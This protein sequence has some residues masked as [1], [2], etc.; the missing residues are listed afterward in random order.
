MWKMPGVGWYQEIQ[1][2][3]S[4]HHKPRAE[5]AYYHDTAEEIF[6]QNPIAIPNLDLRNKNKREILKS[7]Q[8]KSEQSRVT[9]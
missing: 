1:W 8:L 5:K 7:S 9:C 6:S 4:F 2:H 3:V